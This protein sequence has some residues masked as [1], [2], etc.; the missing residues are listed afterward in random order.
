[1]ALGLDFTVVAIP[2]WRLLLFSHSL[3]V[4]GCLMQVCLF[5]QA[6]SLFY[7]TD[8]SLNLIIP[9]YVFQVYYL[10][11][12]ESCLKSFKSGLLSSRGEGQ[13]GIWV[14]G[15]CIGP[16]GAGVGDRAGMVAAA[17]REFLA[18][19]KIHHILFFKY[20]VHNR[21][22]NHDPWAGDCWGLWVSLQGQRC[23][24]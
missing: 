20:L 10:I 16:G 18:A 19:C 12:F 8:P 11:D 6:I 24:I 5:P 15:V 2:G 7:K 1:M 21:S 17:G 3:G 22:C 9:T 4:C 13:A 14:S 23:V